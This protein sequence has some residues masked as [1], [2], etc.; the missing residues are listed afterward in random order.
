[1]DMLTPRNDWRLS[2]GDTGVS[3]TLILQS[4]TSLLVNQEGREALTGVSSARHS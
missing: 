4:S 2:S 1:M 3:I